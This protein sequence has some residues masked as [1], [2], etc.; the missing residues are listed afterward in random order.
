[1]KNKFLLWLLPA[2]SLACFGC[3]STGGDNPNG[4]G[5]GDDDVTPPVRVT[6]VELQPE[7]VLEPGEERTLEVWVLPEEAD[8]RTVSWYCDDVLEQVATIDPLTGKVTAIDTGEAT[9]TVT[10]DEGG[11][12]ADCLVRVVDDLIPVT[13]VELDKPTLDLV[14]GEAA[15]LTATVLPVEASDKSVTWS[16]D[17]KAVA[18]VDPLTGEVT[19]VGSGEATITVTTTYG[20]FT[21]DCL[22]TVSENHIPVE[23]ISL[24]LPTLALT[25]SAMA[26]LTATVLPDDAAN[27]NVTWS[28]DN[29]AVATV[30]GTGL[31]TARGDGKATIT[32]TTVEGEFEA[33]CVVTVDTPFDNVLNAIEDPAFL[34]FCEAH[35]D[36]PSVI[37]NGTWDIGGLKNVPK[38]DTDGNG[39]LSP[40]E[41]AA[42]KA[43]E[44]TD[45][46][47]IVS[48]AGLEYFTGLRFFGGSQTSVSSFDLSHSKMLQFLSLVDNF[49]LT[50]LDVTGCTELLAMDCILDYY[51][52]EMGLREDFVLPTIDLST[53]VKLQE[54]TV[55]NYELSS[56]DLSRNTALIDLECS[57]NRLTSLDVSKCAQLESL[58]CN[59]NLLPTLDVSGCRRLRSLDCSGNRLSTLD[60]SKNSATLIS[61][62]CED[63]PGTGTQFVVKSWFPDNS[64]T[65]SDVLDGMPIWDYDGREITVFFQKVV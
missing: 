10:T 19:A 60:I 53:N 4:N 29:K 59:L 12:T 25:E 39:R 38:W 27:K 63:N 35:M 24:D 64:D 20:G 3:G 50:S 58:L 51:L 44:I 33:H 21:A 30:D 26:Q 49:S 40:E 37:E 11:Y 34:A 32:A 8:N 17:N 52:V 14:E 65:A 1:M 42:V 48:L 55:H 18:N 61:L 62:H 45:E 41:A 28:S 16:S 43:M 54:L 5:N 56:L 23:S 31:V 46:G 15:R 36:S 22:V 7:L 13:G 57:Q 6:G 2:F 47:V 9:I